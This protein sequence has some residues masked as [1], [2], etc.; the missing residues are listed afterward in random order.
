MNICAGGKQIDPR[1]DRC[2]HCGNGPDRGC[3][4][5]AGRCAEK[6]NQ[7]EAA[8]K[9]IAEWECESDPIEIRDLARGALK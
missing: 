2:T 4:I 8:L 3:P 9:Q 1:N 7:M 5:D 6:Y